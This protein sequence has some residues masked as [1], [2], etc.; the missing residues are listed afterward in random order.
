MVR[1]ANKFF[2][3][4]EEAKAFIKNNKGGALYKNTKGSHSK[5]SFAIE[6]CLA[7]LS[8]E[9]TIKYPYCVAWNIWKD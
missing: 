6:A 1:Y 9:D 5:R 7:N 4:E 2:E 8:S 3:T